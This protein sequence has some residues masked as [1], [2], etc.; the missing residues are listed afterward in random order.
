[1]INSVI[2]DLDGTLIDSSEDI[3]HCLKLA[4]KNQNVAM[5]EKLTLS[6]IGPPLEEMIHQLSPGLS[7]SKATDLIANFRELYSSSNFKFSKAYPGI[8]S[9]L[10]HL[11]NKQIPCFIA[12]NKPR[13]LTIE[14][15]N[16]KN[17]NHYFKDI[18]CSGDNN[19]KL[20]SELISFLIDKWNLEPK[21]SFMIGDSPLDIEAAIE[22]NMKSIAHLGGYGKK[23]DLNSS[24]AN[25][26]VQNMS[27]V[28]EIISP[29]TP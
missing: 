10:D 1:M 25:Y 13:R 14:L 12:T 9:L 21:S 29:L 4:Y 5:K 11:K 8:L 18:C 22:C 2:F 24:Q 16:S 15:L 19:F 27:Q 23:S 6:L 17:I 20:K 26:F 7:K 28:L 3:T